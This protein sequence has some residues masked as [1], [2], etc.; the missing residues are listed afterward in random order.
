MQNSSHGRS[1]LVVGA[2]AIALTG[3]PPQPW[4]RQ[5]LLRRR[6]RPA[7]P[8][9][10]QTVIITAEKR[11]S[12][13]QK[14]PVAVTAFTARQRNIMGIT[15]VQDMTDFTPGLTYSGHLDRSAMRGLARLSNDLGRRLVRRHLRR[16]LLFTST[17]NVGLDD[18][19]DRP[20]RN[21]ARPAGHPLWPQRHRR[22]DQHHLQAARPTISPAKSA[23]STATSS[24]PTS[25]APVPARSFPA[26]ISACPASTPTR[27]RAI[28]TTSAA[29][30][31]KAASCTTGT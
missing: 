31:Q 10:S 18:L 28:S 8:E 15:T 5:R 2:S 3:S 30:P 17:Y 20:G 22:P 26:S 24:T 14:V 7:A 12:T 29:D 9:A 23:P 4:P 6:R 21:R 1:L 27:A 19:F 13:V 11:V 25:K 16:R